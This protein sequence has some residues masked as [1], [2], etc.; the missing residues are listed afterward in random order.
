MVKIITKRKIGYDFSK[1]ASWN[2]K[3]GMKVLKSKYHEKSEKERLL[4]VARELGARATQYKNDNPELSKK[5]RN[6]SDMAFR[7]YDNKY[8]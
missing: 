3:Q 7:M 2:I 5:V 6:M 4:T 8:K 1:S